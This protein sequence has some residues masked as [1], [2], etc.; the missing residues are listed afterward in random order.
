MLCRT[1]AAGTSRHATNE[2]DFSKKFEI[3]VPTNR[4]CLHE[5]LS[6]VACK[7][8]AH[9]NIEHVM[10]MLTGLFQRHA[11]FDRKSSSEVGMAAMMI[12]PA[13]AQKI[14][15]IGVASC[16]NHFVN[17]PAIFVITIPIERIMS[18]GRDRSEIGEV[19]KKLVSESYMRT[20]KRPRLS[21]IKPFVQIIGIKQ[22]KI[23]YL[24]AIATDDAKKMPSWNMP[25]SSVTRR[26]PDTIYDLK[27]ISK[28]AICSK[29]SAW[30]SINRI[31]DNRIN[32]PA[33][34]RIF[35]S[36]SDWLRFHPSTSL[37]H[38]PERAGHNP[39]LL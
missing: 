32:R 27:I 28:S 24:W 34:R 7:A 3:V 39:I 10:D 15:S 26:D 5:I 17:R 31:T 9:E 12:L 25:A 11:G 33:S 19:R 37:N 36:H 8:C 22:V 20:V 38:A 35:R 2:I 21:R 16:P 29:I 30:Q 4:A 1:I 23:A 13:I 6:S 14:M 18:Y